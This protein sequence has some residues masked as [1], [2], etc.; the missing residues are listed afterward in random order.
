MVKHNKHRMVFLVLP[1]CLR[2]DKQNYPGPVMG[3]LQL[4]DSAY[5]VLNWTMIIFPM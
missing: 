1:I 5:R 2:G 4:H 3:S